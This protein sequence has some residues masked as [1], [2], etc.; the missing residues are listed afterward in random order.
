MLVASGVV[1][2][3][4]AM[5]TINVGVLLGTPLPNS[6]IVGS[7]FGF[8]ASQHLK[9]NPVVLATSAAAE[10]ALAANQIQFVS[11]PPDAV[12]EANTQGAGL[13]MASGMSVR[14]ASQLLCQPGSVTP[15]AYPGVM[16]QL[17]GKSI[18][19]TVPGP[20]SVT[21]ENISVSLHDADVSLSK[22]NIVPL[23]SLPSM[24]A[25]F[26]AKSV[27]CIVSYPPLDEE[28][29]GQSTLLLD[30]AAGQGPKKLANELSTGFATNQSFAKSNPQAVVG[31]ARAMQKTLQ[32]EANP[33][34]ATAI[35]TKVQPFL[36][37]TAPVSLLASVYKELAPTWS[38]TVSPL[39]LFNTA[40]A[41]KDY[42]GSRP[43]LTL[44]S[45]FASPVQK[46][47]SPPPKKK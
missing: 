18:G 44:K 33:K 32:F 45:L 1:G 17:V 43:S 39:Q 20:A 40:G 41:I 31:F 36:D 12:V 42:T 14:F 46:Y 29:Q 37:P 4:P 13:V 22:V 24:Q 3:A 16:K 27:D 7:D 26:E 6:P 9:V 35:A 10:T 47:V 8:F 11:Q 25:A 34:N 2:A 38:F 30:W 5:T 21:D 15:G 23:G 28:L 19:I